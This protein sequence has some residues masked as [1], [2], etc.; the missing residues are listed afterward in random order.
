MV[1]SC[2]C[3]VICVDCVFIDILPAAKVVTAQ[4][5]LCK[6]RVRFKPH[7]LHLQVLPLTLTSS[8]AA[9]LA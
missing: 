5:P 8:L 3:I 7:L 9:T 6:L 1:I 2:C 4:V